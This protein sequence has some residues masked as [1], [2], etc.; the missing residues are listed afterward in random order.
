MAG[1][2]ILRLALVIGCTF[3]P[4]GAVGAEPSELTGV[5]SVID[6]DTIEIHGARIRLHGIDAPESAQLCIDANDKPW[7]CGQRASLAL[8]ERIGRAP[9][10]CR[11]TDTDRY[12]RMIAVC[13]RGTEDL[14]AWLVA[15]GWAVAYRRYSGDYVA[16]EDEAREARRNIW[17]S[18][19]VMPWDWRRGARIVARAPA[20]ERSQGCA[21]KGNINREGER[22]YHVPD[23]RFYEP[24]RIDTSKG[25]RWFCS[26]AEARAAGWR[27][28]RQ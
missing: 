23:G 27:R 18:R 21:I 19:F 14:N 20:T 26:E 5:A 10:S 2:G 13:S 12:G 17:S 9:V 11:R 25:E 16:R 4:L 7:R 28:S 15:E 3:V 6:G 24:T 8:A 22:I 1:K